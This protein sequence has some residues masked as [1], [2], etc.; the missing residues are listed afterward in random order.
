MNFDFFKVS[1]S[2]LFVSA[3]GGHLC[4]HCKSGCYGENHLRKKSIKRTNTA[5]YCRGK[6]DTQKRAQRSLAAKQNYPNGRFL[7]SLVQHVAL[8]PIS[9][10]HNG[11]VQPYN[12]GPFGCL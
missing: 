12:S 1:I 10:L 7:F 5:G 2:V 4:Q 6:K 9:C 11:L 8:P 3:F